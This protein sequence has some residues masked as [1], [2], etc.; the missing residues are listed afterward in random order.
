MNHR[1]NF[2][3][4]ETLNQNSTSSTAQK[5]TTW[6]IDELDDDQ[7]DTSDIPEWTE[8]DWARAKQGNIHSPRKKGK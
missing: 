7:I 8:R 5:N 1:E 4:R 2:A 3:Y 6:S